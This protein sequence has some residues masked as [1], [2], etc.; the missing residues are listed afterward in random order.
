MPSA[1]ALSN[2]F[3]IP[4]RLSLL[5]AHNRR[6]PA[7]KFL[8]KIIGS[9]YGLFRQD[10]HILAQR[11]AA[12]HFKIDLLLEW[13]RTNEALAWLCL[14]T[15][16]NPDN[17]LAQAM[18]EQLKKQLHIDDFHR[19]SLHPTQQGAYPAS[20]NPIQWE[21]V[22]G[23]RELK[24]ILESDV[25][26]PFLE[27]DIYRRYRVPLPNGILFYGPPGCGKTFIAR[28]LASMMKYNFIELKPS[29]LASIYVHGTQGKIGDTFREAEA[30]GP[31]LLFFD[32]IDAFIPSRNRETSHHYSA[33]VNEF[34]A[35]MNECTERRI[36][37][38]GATNYLNH[39]DAAARRPGRFDKKIYVGPPDLEARIE[40]IKLYMRE[41]PQEEIELFTLLEDKQWYSF[42]DLELIVNQAA[43]DALQHRQPIKRQ[44]L[45]NV[46]RRIQPSIDAKMID[47]MSNE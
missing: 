39:V 42:A 18:K 8:D 9:D 35:Q 16:I 24:L 28:K 27:P 37:V 7:L 45:E 23:M 2:Q 4:S 12:L 34:L 25:I 44:H 15:E 14:E 36:L 10:P 3:H 6:G 22:A 5:I 32:E 29:D 41:R 17:V 30:R 20:S 11:Q 40:A 38:I 46:F 26:M 1:S 31:T 21:G 33:E 43:R 13:N 19:D 47:E